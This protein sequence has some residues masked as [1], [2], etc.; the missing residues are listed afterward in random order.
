MEIPA[1]TNIISPHPL[2]DVLNPRY[3]SF[4]GI[5]AE[6]FFISPPLKPMGDEM[7]AFL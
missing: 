1:K 5:S 4:A 6:G 3:F 7:A 2:L